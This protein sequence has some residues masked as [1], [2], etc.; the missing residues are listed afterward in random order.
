MP[1]RKGQT[2]ER[3][4]SRYGAYFDKLRRVQALD[5][6]YTAHASAYPASGLN[7]PTKRAILRLLNREKFHISKERRAYG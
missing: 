6:R 7:R 5:R 3:Y 1:S 4:K 2:V